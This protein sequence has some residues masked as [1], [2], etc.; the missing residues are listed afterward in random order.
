MALKFLEFLLRISLIIPINI[1]YI[2]IFGLDLSG[3]QA[4]RSGISPDKGR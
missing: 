4:F 3:I 1:L 2:L